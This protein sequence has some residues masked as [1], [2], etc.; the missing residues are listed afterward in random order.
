MGDDVAEISYGCKLSKEV[1]DKLTPLF[2]KKR[3]G[4]DEINK[5][6]FLQLDS[7]YET[8]EYLLFVRSSFKSV[9]NGSETFPKDTFSADFDVWDGEINKLLT[10]N[11]VEAES[12]IGW[13]LTGH[14]G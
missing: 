14:Y 12:S 10:E 3:F 5:T 9:C 7:P 11:G 6:S 13:I 4:W 1:F 8:Y 2:F